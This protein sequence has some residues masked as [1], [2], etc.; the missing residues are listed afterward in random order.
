MHVTCGIERLIKLSSHYS[1]PSDRIQVDWIYAGHEDLIENDLS[2]SRR[3]Q[4]KGLHELVAGL[5]QYCYGGI[6]SAACK[7]TSAWFYSLSRCQRHHISW[8]R[9]LDG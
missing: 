9:H 7:V 3:R 2:N 1:L 6:N 8:A 4:S 5:A